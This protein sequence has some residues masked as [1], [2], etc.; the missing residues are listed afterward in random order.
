[1]SASPITAET[2]PH[3]LL[4]DVAAANTLV[5]M[6]R[7]RDAARL[8]Y[9]A[10]VPAYAEGHPQ[11]EKRLAEA[12]REVENE[13]NFVRSVYDWKKNSD[14]ETRT[15]LN[16]YLAAYKAAS[17]DYHAVLAEEERAAKPVEHPDPALALWM[18]KMRLQSVADKK[19]PLVAKMENVEKNVIQ[20][21]FGFR[22]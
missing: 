14:A 7:I 20:L 9:E 13:A 3:A 18:Q 4:P 16:E 2:A 15:I 12:E 22:K 8:L 1:M 21:L 6:R 5:L 19:A 11:A 17:V 10:R